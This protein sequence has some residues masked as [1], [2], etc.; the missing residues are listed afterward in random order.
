MG[1]TA[2]HIPKLLVSLTLMTAHIAMGHPKSRV[3]ASEMLASVASEASDILF[4]I[5]IANMSASAGEIATR[6][7]YIGGD[8]LEQQLYQLP[9]D[10]QSLCLQA[11]Q[12]LLKIC[13]VGQ[14]AGPS[15][16]Q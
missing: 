1:T 7:R 6:L 12:D 11:L 2:R 13:K 10:I 9:P 4:P 16:E 15:I 8:L 14:S 3:F 5:A